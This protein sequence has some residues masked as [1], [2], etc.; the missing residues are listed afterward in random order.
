MCF[1]S[2]H[3]ASL[4]DNPESGPTMIPIYG[5]K[6][7]TQRVFKKLTES[8]TGN[9]GQSLHFNPSGRFWTL[10]QSAMLPSKRRYLRSPAQPQEAE[11]GHHARPRL[12]SN[13]ILAPLQG[14]LRYIRC[15]LN[16]HIRY[17]T[18]KE[19]KQT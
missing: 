2:A 7:V 6:K 19:R 4:H 14:H 18:M 5:L 3:V 16:H 13:R 12:W 1:Q 15:S 10:N 9:K 8:D 17:F 11:P